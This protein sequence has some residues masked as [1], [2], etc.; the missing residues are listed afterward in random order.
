VR[1][2]TGKQTRTAAIILAAVLLAIQL[3]PVD[4][5]NPPVKADVQTPADVKAILRR[6]CF[7]C[8]SHETTW[9]WYSRVAPFSWLVAR[10]VHEGREDLNF[11]RW[12]TYDFE[13]QDLILRDIHKVISEDEMP[14]QSYLLG[15]P[16]ARLSPQDKKTLLDWSRLGLPEEHSLED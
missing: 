2:P 6:S 14:L 4:T 8:H 3:V 7:D 9:P 10:H 12:P 13:A 15:H 16:G 11:S 1:K 5:S